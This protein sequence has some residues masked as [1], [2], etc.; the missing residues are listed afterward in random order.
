MANGRC[1][2]HGGLSTGPRKKEGRPRIRVART[3]HGEYSAE[4]K[5]AWRRTTEFMAETRAL[6]AQIKAGTL[7]LE[8][9]VAP[10]LRLVGGPDW[11]RR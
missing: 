9:A 11:E 4:S 10:R 7:W 3:K 1:R 6:L 5:A 2:V 8:P